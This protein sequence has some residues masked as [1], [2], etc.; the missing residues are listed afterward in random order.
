MLDVR[1]K[2][3][4]QIAVDSVKDA[5]A[6]LL[7]SSHQRFYAQTITGKFTTIYLLTMA[8]P[9]VKDIIT[10]YVAEDNGLG[11]LDGDLSYRAWLTKQCED[12]FDQDQQGYVP[13]W[14]ISAN[15]DVTAGW[16]KVQ[17]TSLQDRIES[18]DAGGEWSS[19]VADRFKLREQPD[20]V[21]D[22]ASPYY[23]TSGHH[24]GVAVHAVAW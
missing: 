9:N 24:R 23:Y 11:F 15:P 2:T 18:L 3:S 10:A 8:I 1:L 20:L 19:A 6:L 4:V 16:R 13:L 17:A 14:Q 7:T 22:T 5:R 21:G 12:I